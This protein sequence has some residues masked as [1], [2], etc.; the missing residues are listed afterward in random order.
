[1]NAVCVTE[2]EPVLE[3]LIVDKKEEKIVAKE[4]EEERG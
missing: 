3:G 4:G 2:V 1:M